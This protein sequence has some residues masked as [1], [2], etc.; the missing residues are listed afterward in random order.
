M[1]KGEFT[2]PVAARSNIEKAA[3]VKFWRANG[4]F[5]NQRDALY[6]DGRK[7]VLFQHVPAYIT[8]LGHAYPEIFIFS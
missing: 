7:I 1:S 8:K 6:Y 4:K 5:T 2:V 3:V